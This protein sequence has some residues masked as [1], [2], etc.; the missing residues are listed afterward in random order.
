MD[1]SNED[2]AANGGDGDRAHHLDTLLGRLL[3]PLR[4]L[5]RALGVVEYRLHLG[6]FHLRVLDRF[7][8]HPRL[9]HLRLQ[10]F[11]ALPD[12]SVPN[13]PKHFPRAPRWGTTNLLSGTRERIRLQ[14]GEAGVKD[15]VFGLLD[16]GHGDLDRRG[17]VA[18]GPLGVSLSLANVALASSLV[19]LMPYVGN[20]VTPPLLKIRHV[21]LV[22]AGLL[23]SARPELGNLLVGALARGA[24]PRLKL[25][26]TLGRG[27]LDV[28][29]SLTDLLLQLPK[30]FRRVRHRFLPPCS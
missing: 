28:L 10:P 14:S 7:L 13:P 15:G 6:D 9:L 12:R 19:D 24:D 26:L 11:L 29:L 5:K 30:L 18:L 4:G 25:L 8:S 27:R 22:L 23:L 16:R 21:S 3:D 2:Q 20:V 1:Q 17:R